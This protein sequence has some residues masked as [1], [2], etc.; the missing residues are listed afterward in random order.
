MRSPW[1][2]VM[3]SVLLLVATPVA[4][5][6][7]DW[8]VFKVSQPTYFTK[9]TKNWVRVRRGM[10]IPNK[11]WVHTGR[12]GRVQLRRGEEFVIF[13]PN[14]LTRLYNDGKGK[15][16]LRQEFGKLLLDVEARNHKHFTVK[17]PLGNVYRVQRR[18]D[19]RALSAQRRESQQDGR[20]PPRRHDH[21]RRGRASGCR[22]DRHRSRAYFWYARQYAQTGLHL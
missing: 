17:T 9:D 6:A 1:I 8:V 3:F 19:D 7:Q 21:N 18:Q 2:A 10:R 22:R 20:G 11:S 4:A 15:T 12:R 16:Y 13:S 14:T 5:I